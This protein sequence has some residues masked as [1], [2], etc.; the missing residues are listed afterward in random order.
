MHNRRPALQRAE[1]ADAGA[2]G[3][4]G[5][6]TPGASGTSAIALTPVT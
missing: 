3:E 5:T 2:P 4:V 1:A 6:T